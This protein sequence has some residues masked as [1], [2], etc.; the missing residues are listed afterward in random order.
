[1]GMIRIELA[2]SFPRQVK[3][4]SAMQGGHAK[5]IAEAIAWLSSEVLPKAVE[6]DHALHADG[7]FPEDRFG[8]TDKP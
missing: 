3:T 2:G 1:M 6:Q 5:A 8:L 7:H 4:V